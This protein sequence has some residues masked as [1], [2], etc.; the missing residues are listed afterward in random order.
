[1]NKTERSKDTTPG[2][3]PP[4]VPGVPKRRTDDAEP[5]VTGTLWVGVAVMSG[6]GTPDAVTDNVRV[7]DVADAGELEDVGELMMLITR[8]RD[9]N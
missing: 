2:P 7:P 8:A 4:G 6:A 5:G 3:D 1:L 9:Y